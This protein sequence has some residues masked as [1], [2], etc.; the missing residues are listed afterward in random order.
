ML[1][2]D[3]NNIMP[4]FS[5]NKD[6]IDDLNVKFNQLRAELAGFKIK[7]PLDDK[8]SQTLINNTAAN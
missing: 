1:C 8:S 4:P 6:D 2:Q 5:G 3:N 7:I